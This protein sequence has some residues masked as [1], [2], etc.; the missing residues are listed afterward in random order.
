MKKILYVLGSAV[1]GVAIAL[2]AWQLGRR[3]AGPAVTEQRDS[4]AA[5][6]AENTAQDVDA[7]AEGAAPLDSSASTNEPAEPTAV[8][9]PQPQL[10]RMYAGP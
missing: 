4:T 7:S 10:A 5:V 9:Q 6:N 2:G 8:Q 3:G 1:V